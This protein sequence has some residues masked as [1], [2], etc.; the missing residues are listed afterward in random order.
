MT[1]YPTDPDVIHEQVKESIQYKELDS[2]AR[3]M[4]IG[5]SISKVAVLIANDTEFNTIET[6]RASQR[7]QPN[8]GNYKSMGYPIYT[9]IGEQW[10]NTDKGYESIYLKDYTLITFEDF[11]EW[12][13]KN[14][15]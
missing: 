12:I 8:E 5:A 3:E 14:G 9:G 7:Y 11:V 13:N 6:Y 15:D 1:L 4:A 10:C 2:E